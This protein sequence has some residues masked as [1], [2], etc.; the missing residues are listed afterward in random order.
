M[1]GEETKAVS[2]N[3]NA[4][5]QASAGDPSDLD[6]T[7][8]RATLTGDA[9]A[10]LRRVDYAKR[11]DSLSTYLM[12]M[13]GLGTGGLSVYS[14]WTAKSGTEGFV[15]RAASRTMALLSV[16]TFTGS[17]IGIAANERIAAESTLLALLATG[18][19]TSSVAVAQDGSSAVFD[20]VIAL[21][22]GGF[23]YANLSDMIGDD[24]LVAEAVNLGL[25]PD[26]NGKSLGFYLH[27]VF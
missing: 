17:L 8:R 26:P 10:V 19:V 18:V 27:G 1:A 24:M 7:L 5:F 13:F 9:E 3:G 2:G 14:A 25:V 23:A 12:M 11:A 6:E 4:T 22:A 21:A 20:V 15:N 16:P